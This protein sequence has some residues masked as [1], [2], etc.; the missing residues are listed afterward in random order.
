MEWTSTMCKPLDT[1]L[2]DDNVG[3]NV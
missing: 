3:D 2:D 1:Y